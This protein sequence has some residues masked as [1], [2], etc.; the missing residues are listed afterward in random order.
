MLLVPHRGT[1]QENSVTRKAEE[2]LSPPIAIYQ[3]IHG[4]SMPGAGS[5]VSVNDANIIVSSIKQA[6]EGE[7]LVVRCVE[8]SGKSVTA[9]VDFSFLNRRWTGTFRPCEIKSLRLDCKNRS[10]KEVNLLEEDIHIS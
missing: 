2:F 3:G 5:F 6:E 9:T 1:W 8:T 4:G 7:D 10:V